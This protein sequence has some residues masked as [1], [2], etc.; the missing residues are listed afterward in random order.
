MEDSEHEPHSFATDDVYVTLFMSIHL[1]PD[2]VFRVYLLHQGSEDS[3]E[4][5]KDNHWIGKIRNIRG[6]GPDNVCISF[7]SCA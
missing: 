2:R 3:G 1:V 4:T 7:G 5:L 6:D